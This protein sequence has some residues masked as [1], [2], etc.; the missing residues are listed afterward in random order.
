MDIKKQPFGK[1]PDGKIIDHFTL[2]NKGGLETGI[3]TYGGII[4]SLKTLDKNGNLADI[5]LGCDTLDDYLNE[6]SYF[7]CIVGRCVNR[8]R[9]ARFSLNGIEYMVSKNCGENHI[10]GGIKGFD[11]AVWD[12]TEIKAANSVA[13][14]LTYVSKDSE[15]GYPGNLKCTVIYTLTNDNELKISYE[16]QTDKTTVLNLTN[17]SYFNLAGY[18]A[19][20]VFDHEIMINADKFTVSDETL[21]P[22]G[23]IKSVKGTPLDFTKSIAIGARIAKVR[24]GYDLNYILNSSD[25][26]LALAARVYELKTGRIME[27]Y[28]TQPGIQLYTG[29][30][31]NGSSKGKGAVYNKHSG[32]CLETQHYPN[33]PNIPNFPSTVLEPGQ[34]YHQVT[35]H[36]FSVE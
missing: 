15:E 36:R 5:V 35:V 20:D 10:H 27:I 26:S 34:K 2:T 3:I 11:K 19:S 23:E 33:S 7:G 31:L 17:H 24:G 4:V 8:I 18:N 13:L 1:T 22:T 9:N 12:A 29:N 32:F 16:A 6:T 21:I 28:T 25:G 14:K 30:F